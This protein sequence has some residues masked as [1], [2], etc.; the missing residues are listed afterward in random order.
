MLALACQPGLHVLQG[1]AGMDHLMKL[2]ARRIVDLAPGLVE[3]LGEPG[4]HLSIDRVV[5]GQ[6]SSRS[7]EA[8]NSLRIDDP[9]FDPGVT[10]RLGPLALVT[11]ACLHHSLADF[12]P[13]QPSVQR[14]PV[15][16]RV[17]KR[18]LQR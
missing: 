18:T 15:F 5:L 10:Q 16:Y 3:C 11:A 13:A 14:T 1:V 8:T 2:L 17:C 4:N 9:D 12:V 6:P 7:S